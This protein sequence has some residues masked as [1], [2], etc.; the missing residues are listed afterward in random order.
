LSLCKSLIIRSH[1]STD[2]QYNGKKK[3]QNWQWKM[4]HNWYKTQNKAIQKRKQSIIGLYL[5]KFDDTKGIIR[6]HSSKD[7]QYNGQRKRTKWETMV[8][9]TLNRKLKIVKREPYNKS[10]VSSGTQK[11]IT[12][13]A[14]HVTPVVLLFNDTHLIWYENCDSRQYMWQ[15]FK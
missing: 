1:N 3:G 2:R 5:I 9:K 11:W 15:Q 10:R 13:P 6:S 12:V 7:R 4:K 14:P 8:Y